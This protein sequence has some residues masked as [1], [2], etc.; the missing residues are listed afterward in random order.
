MIW[1]WI[2]RNNDD[3]LVIALLGITFSVIWIKI[4][5]ASAHKMHLIMSSAKDRGFRLGVCLNWKLLESTKELLT[6]WGR[7]THICVG[8]LIIVGSDN[9]LAQITNAGILLIEPLETN[10]SEILIKI[11][12]FIFNEM[13][14]KTSS[15]NRRPFCLGLNVLMLP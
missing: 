10:F 9:G 1:I 6:H 15:A 14:L 4:R 13:H 2:N 7:V 12:T 8:N 11:H 5:K 3:S